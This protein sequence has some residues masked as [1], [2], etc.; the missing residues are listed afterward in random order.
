MNNQDSFQLIHLP[1]KGGGDYRHSEWHWPFDTETS[2]MVECFTFTCK[3]VIDNVDV[4]SIYIPVNRDFTIDQEFACVSRFLTRARDT[5]IEFD[6]TH[7]EIRAS[8]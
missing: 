3:N 4:I 5:I 6:H 1:V 8:W 7:I 2:F